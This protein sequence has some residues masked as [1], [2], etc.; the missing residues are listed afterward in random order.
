MPNLLT[1]FAQLTGE[2]RY[3]SE[4]AVRGLTGEK[5]EQSVAILHKGAK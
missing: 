2:Q 5:V 1:V 4:K 3:R